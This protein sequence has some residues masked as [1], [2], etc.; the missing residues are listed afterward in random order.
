M[1]KMFGKFADTQKVEEKGL[2]KERELHSTMT[3]LST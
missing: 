3:A 2:V 1:S